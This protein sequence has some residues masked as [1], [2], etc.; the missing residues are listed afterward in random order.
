MTPAQFDLEEAI[1]AFTVDATEDQP[2]GRMESAMELLCQ[3]LDPKAWG[4]LTP[5]QRARL[6]SVNGAAAELCVALADKIGRLGHSA[7]ALFGG[8]F[9]KPR[10]S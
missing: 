7:E 3:L 6:D 10:A 8:D 2:N 5:E 9:T 4:A 1:R